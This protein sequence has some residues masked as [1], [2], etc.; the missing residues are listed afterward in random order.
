MECPQVGRGGVLRQITSNWSQ[1]CSSR[2][3]LCKSCMNEVKKCCGEGFGWICALNRWV[4][5]C[6]HISSC[7]ITCQVL[8]YLARELCR[9]IAALSKF[10]PF[11]VSVG[12]QEVGDGGE[13]AFW[14]GSPK[15][16]RDCQDF[17]K[18]LL[19]L[20]LNLIIACLYSLG[21]AMEFID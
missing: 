1:K 16:T 8:N 12:G 10:A 4:Q 20:G 15:F 6:A 13:G 17:F 18:R 11:F 5:E 7:P 14:A 9:Q 3:A 21:E 2:I 19:L